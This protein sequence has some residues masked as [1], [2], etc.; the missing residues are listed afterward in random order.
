VSNPNACKERCHIPRWGLC[1]TASPLK[2]LVL[3]LTHPL[4]TSLIR[5]SA[6]GFQGTA[7]LAYSLQKRQGGQRK[8][9]HTG[10]F[11]R[12]K[13]KTEGAFHKEAWGNLLEL[14]I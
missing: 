5:K 11:C 13:V 8:S 4:V 12:G 1:P 6:R 3:G 14:R 10:V 7:R 2:I 9:G